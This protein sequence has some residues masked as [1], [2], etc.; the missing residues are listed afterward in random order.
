[1]I[2]EKVTVST[3]TP[4]WKYVESRTYKYAFQETKNDL[5][6]QSNRENEA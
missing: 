4:Q 6:W 1:M 2:H 5:P 3:Q